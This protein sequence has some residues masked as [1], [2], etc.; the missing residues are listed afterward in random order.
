MGAGVDVR[1]GVGSDP[2]HGHEDDG[3]E[4]DDGGVEAEYGGGDGGARRR[5]RRAAAWVPA[6]ET[7]DDVAGRVE[8]AVVVAELGQDE[9]RREEPDDGQE[10]VGLLPRLAGRYGAECDEESGGGE[11]GDGLGQ[12]SRP[13]DGEDEHAEEEPDGH[14]LGG[15]GV[16]GRRR[17]LSRGAGG[18]FGRSGHACAPG[19]DAHPTYD[20]RAGLARDAPAGLLLRGRVPGARV[21]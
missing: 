9:N 21:R 13:R 1:A 6:A 3:R 10:G 4:E 14:D 20:P 15:E 16:H 2:A 5:R 12:P 7:G 19:R 8:Q 17:G 11:G 18:W